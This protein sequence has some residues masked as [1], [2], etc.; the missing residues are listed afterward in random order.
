M[1]KPFRD[2]GGAVPHGFLVA[3]IGLDGDKTFPGHA[4]EQSALAGQD[5]H[6]ESIRV[7]GTGDTAPDTVRPSGHKGDPAVFPGIHVELLR[8]REQNVM[9]WSSDR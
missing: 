4:I 8:C 3:H 1:A 9:Y 5:S 7:Q 6:S 2:F